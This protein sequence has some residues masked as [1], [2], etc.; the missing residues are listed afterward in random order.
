ME[1]GLEHMQRILFS[2]ILMAGVSA[3]LAVPTH[4]ED[5][6]CTNATLHGSFA[7]TAQGTT[8]ASLGLPAPLTGAF[9]SSGFAEFDGKGQFELTATSS[10]AGVVQGPAT[11]SGTYSVNGDCSYTS[12]ASNG[13]SFSAVIVDHGR[14]ILIL[15]TNNGVVITGT[16]KVRGR[17]EPNE[18]TNHEGKACDNRSFAGSYGFLAEGFAGAPFGPLAGVGVVNVSLDGT[19]TMTAQRSVD[20]VID[21]GPLQLKGTY[22]FTSGCTVQLS[23]DVG[24]HFSAELVNRDEALFIETDP[25]TAVIVKSKRI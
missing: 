7:F 8:L 6:Y 24:F 2:T 13:A 18:I 14:E 17:A 5:L 11:V 1:R 19:F 16:A 20:G 3:G 9:A 23:F 21:P 25:G 10:F 12:Q 22:Q 4:A 15:Q